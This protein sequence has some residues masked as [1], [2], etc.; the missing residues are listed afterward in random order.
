[1][2]NKTFNDNLGYQY[3]KA[4]VANGTLSKAEFFLF[5]VLRGYDYSK[6]YCFPSERQLAKDCL[7][8][9]RAIRRQLQKLSDVGL[10]TI[11]KTKGNSIKR[12][13]N[14]A[15]NLYR[16]KS[17]YTADYNALTQPPAVKTPPAPQKPLE[18]NPSAIA[19]PLGEPAKP[20]IQPPTP[21]LETVE[22]KVDF[23]IAEFGKR[24]KDS[25]NP[26]YSIRK[27]LKE[28]QQILM[29]RY[30]KE[31]YLATWSHFLA[32]PG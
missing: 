10:I 14:Y 23:L 13:S 18:S 6:G 29:D 19:A 15:Q 11:E 4:L 31:A 9:D 22:Q 27:H 17:D 26:T 21:S 28:R 32:G 7:C 5:S 1:M 8:S 3:A 16:F 24:Y 20:A 25:P 2:S 12:Q 30:G